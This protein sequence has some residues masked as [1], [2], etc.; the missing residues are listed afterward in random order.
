MQCARKQEGVTCNVQANKQ[1]GCSA[2]RSG[3]AHAQ[4]SKARQSKA[5]AGL[6]GSLL[7]L[8]PLAMH[9]KAC[10]RNMPAQFEPGQPQHTAAHLR[11]DLDELARQEL[12]EQR[13][14][15][16]SS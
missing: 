1:A 6:H 4:R 14:L 5:Q 3:Q 2:A 10:R 7:V 13:L 9:T 12:I 15:R 16:R 8:A 11:G